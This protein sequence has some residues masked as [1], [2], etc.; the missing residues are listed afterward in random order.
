MEQYLGQLKV[1]KVDWETITLEWWKEAQLNETQSEY[2]LTDEPKDLTAMRDLLLDNIVPDILAVL[3]KHDIRKWDIGA[4]M[5]TV[6]ATYN[7]TFNIAVGKA[8]GTFEEGK[9]HQQM[10]E[11]IKMSDIVRIS[12]G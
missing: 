4:V 10:P 11:N 5:N 12:N 1:M 9:P 6:V 8:F 7:H 3:M 2:L